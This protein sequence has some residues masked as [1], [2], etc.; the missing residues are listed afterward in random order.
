[1]ALYAC[2]SDPHLTWGK[3]IS[4]LD[5]VKITGIRKF[6][7]VLDWCSKNSAELLIPGDLTDSAHGWYLYLE[8]VKSL[9]KYKVIPIVVYGQHDM[10]FRTKET[11]IMNALIKNNLI[12][13]V[14]GNR[15]PFYGYSWSDERGY[16]NDDIDRK[17]KILLIHAPI[18]TNQLYP[19]QVFMD[20]RQFLRENKQFDLIVCGDIHRRFMVEY[21][22][23]YIVN[24]GSMLRLDADE[25]MF[26]HKPGFWVYDTN[27]KNVDWV[28]IP[29]EEAERVLSRVHIERKKEI[30]LMMKDFIDSISEQVDLDMDFEKNIMNFIKSNEVDSK[31]Q[32]ILEEVMKGE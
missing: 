10:Y 24:S 29:H 15:L 26:E 27:K 14:E 23:R 17:C 19:N 18:T 22:G 32:N 6:N 4:R 1:M 30:N 31:V 12:H 5:D 20:A 21:Q 16:E 8:L 9:L 13:L 2:L 25:Y 7:F 3:P 11:T 28:E